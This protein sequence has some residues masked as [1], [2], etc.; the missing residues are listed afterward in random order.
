MA[1]LREPDT[2]AGL[3]ERLGAADDSHTLD[4]SLGLLRQWSNRAPIAKLI[5][6][7]WACRDDYTIALPLGV[8]RDAQQRVDR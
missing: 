3:L 1:D 8:L 2:I 4:V 7:Y 5:A 6:R